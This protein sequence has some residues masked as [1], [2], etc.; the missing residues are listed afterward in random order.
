MA[1]DS[2][3]SLNAVLRDQLSVN[4]KVFN[5]HDVEYYLWIY[6]DPIY[7]RDYRLYQIDEVDTSEKFDLS[8][9]D[10]VLH[11]A[12][13]PWY[14]LNS[15]YLKRDSGKHIYRMHFVCVRDSGVVTSLYFSYIIQ[16][17]DVERPYIYMNPKDDNTFDV[18]QLSK[19][20]SSTKSY[21]STSSDA[22]KPC[23]EPPKP[24]ILK[25]N[26]VELSGDKSSSELNIIKE[27]T[28]AGWAKL[29]NYRPKKG[30]ICVYTDFTSVKDEHGRIHYYP[31]IKVGDGNA[32]VVDLPFVGE[33]AR[34]SLMDELNGHVADS[35]IHVTQKEK[36]FWNNK[37]NCYVQGEELIFTRQ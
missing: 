23:P 24:Q 22:V 30:E 37:L 32:Y 29:S 13:R 3:F 6:V 27:N 8:I 12:G 18:N 31:E 10:I 16:R 19:F 14:R 15:T 4:T 2:V 26:G 7:S 5:I 9:P 25:I 33:S 1:L 34:K 35:S 21:S 28:T 17:N 11:D 20:Q 36:T